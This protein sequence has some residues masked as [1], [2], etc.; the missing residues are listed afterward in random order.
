M[1]MIARIARALAPYT[2]KTIHNVYHLTTTH[3]PITTFATGSLTST[4]PLLSSA[5]R[6][7][8]FIL[9]KIS[10]SKPKKDTEMVKTVSKY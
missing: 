1:N 4:S 6:K 5:A 10:A 2:C 9:H 7:Q 3:I 8:M